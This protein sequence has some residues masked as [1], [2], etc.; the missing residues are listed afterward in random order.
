ME[1]KYRTHIVYHIQNHF[2]NKIFFPKKQK[3]YQLITFCDA[4]DEQDDLS[5][6]KFTTEYENYI[7]TQMYIK[8]K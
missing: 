4:G 5:Q 8:L 3:S 2:L 6:M 1:F 7:N